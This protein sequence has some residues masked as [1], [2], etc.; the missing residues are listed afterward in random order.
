MEQTVRRGMRV[1]TTEPYWLGLL[2]PN[3]GRV[4]TAAVHTPR[5][6]VTLHAWTGGVGDHPVRAGVVLDVSAAELEEILA[7]VADVEVVPGE[8]ARPT[9]VVTRGTPLA[10]SDEPHGRTSLAAIAYVVPFTGQRRALDNL[11]PPL[12]VSEAAP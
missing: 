2:W 7:G 11:P 4:Q 9:R 10:E 12:L 5:G 1:E 3:I 6:V 8:D